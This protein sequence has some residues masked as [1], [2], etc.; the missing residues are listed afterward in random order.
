[1]T[2][3]H[4]LIVLGAGPAGGNGALA[5]AAAGLKV[6]LL[7]EQVEPGGQVW[8]APVRGLAPSP[9]GPEARAGDRLRGRLAAST[10][11]IRLQRR[12]WSVTGRFRI[13]AVGPG[14]SESLTAPYVLLASGA[15]ERIVPFPGW[16]LPGVIG[17]GAAT[18]LLKS[19]LVIPG[20]RVVVAGCGPLL[21]AVAAG[22]LK[23]GGEVVA[24]VDLSSRADWLRCTPRL[25]SRPQLMLRG[26]GWLIKIA[27][28]GVPIHFRHGVRGAS[29]DD[30]VER[31][32]LAPVDS[33]GAFVTGREMTL[34]AD[35][36]CVGHGLIPGGEVAKLLRARHAYDATRGG[37]IAVTDEDGRTSLPGMFCAGDGAGI[38]G[39]DAAEI[40]GALAGYAIARD[41]GALAGD[42]FARRTRSL[43]WRERL[44]G[45]FSDA[46]SQLMALRPAQVA[47]VEPGTIVCRCEDVT[48]REIDAAFDDGAR[49]VNQLKHFT[50]C[51]MGPCQGRMCGDVAAELLALRVGARQAVGYWTARPPLRPVALADMSGP[52]TYDDIPIPEPA[53]L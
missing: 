24:V 34:E 29:G 14:G 9:V 2:H 22:I 35:A 30:R 17:L 13:D 4:D 49:D 19:H 43:R 33:G 27:A 20:R 36:L 50:R 41:A 39:A 52:F 44:L 48:R 5:A 23:L 10:V 46:V 18:V 12:V 51:G 45:P 53:P 1:M 3:T 6:A 38:R 31:I 40:S 15:H 25:G 32:T 7:D 16:T 11:D 42:R 26:A 28:R 37:W 47:A 21:A 8:R